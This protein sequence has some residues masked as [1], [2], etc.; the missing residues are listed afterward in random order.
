MC[1]LMIVILGVMH[2]KLVITFKP[3]MELLL[4]VSLNVR[5]FH[6]LRVL[7][8]L[9]ILK[10]LMK[11]LL[12]MVNGIMSFAHSSVMAVDEKCRDDVQFKTMVVQLFREGSSFGF[13]IRGRYIRDSNIS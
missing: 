13:T 4:I 11:C 3:S 7:G 10:Y 1:V 9:L 8:Q 2:Y 6:F 5:S 12:D